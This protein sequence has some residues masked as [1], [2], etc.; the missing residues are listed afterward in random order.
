MDIQGIAILASTIIG[1][2][3]IIAALYEYIQQGK[4]K[5]VEFFLQARNRLF[6]NDEYREI[7]DLLEIDDEKLKTIE[8]K[9][10]LEFIGYFEEIALLINSKVI[11]PEVA[12]YMFG[13]Y[14]LKCWD[15]KNFWIIERKNLDKND[16]YWAIFRTFVKDMKK[17]ASNTDYSKRRYKL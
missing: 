1:L 7:I 16:P 17:I 8:F 13:Y 6:E 5:R 10:K 15:S 2:L 11:R 9:V 14:A 4:I 3:T 12:Q